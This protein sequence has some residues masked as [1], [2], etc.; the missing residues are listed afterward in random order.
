G[1]RQRKPPGYYKALHK[2]ELP[3]TATLFENDESLVEIAGDDSLYQDAIEY[4]M[5]AGDVEPDTVEEALRGSEAKEW[6]KAIEA[7]LSQIEKLH[8]WDIVEAPPD[9]NIT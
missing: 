8:T 5:L 1:H 2:R 3:E 7:E 9:A 6:T 4:A